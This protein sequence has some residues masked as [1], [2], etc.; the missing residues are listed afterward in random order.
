MSA[1]VRLAVR[2]GPRSS[3]LRPTR[4]GGRVKRISPGVWG[5][6]PDSLSETVA[7]AGSQDRLGSSGDHRDGGR[8]G[9]AVMGEWHPAQAEPRSTRTVDRFRGRCRAGARS[10][11]SC[12][13]LGRGGRETHRLLSHAPLPALCGALLL[14]RTAPSG[15]RVMGRSIGTARGARRAPRPPGS[16]SDLEPVDGTC[17]ATGASV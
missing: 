10:A 16:S 12:A 17:L 6:E 5:R 3:P 1:A 2:C 7:L 15:A 9:L 11:P 8:G 14:S 4:R 13:F